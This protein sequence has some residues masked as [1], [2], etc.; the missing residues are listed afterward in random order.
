MKRQATNITSEK[1]GS[2]VR[3]KVNRN[4]KSLIYI[5]AECQASSHPTAVVKVNF[6]RTQN[7]ESHNALVLNIIL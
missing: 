3:V 6:F 2:L 5:Y 4:K 1:G 7:Y